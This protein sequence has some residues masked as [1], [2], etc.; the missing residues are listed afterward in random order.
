MGVLVSKTVAPA[1]LFSCF[2][3]SD[4]GFI[5]PGLEGIEAHYKQR[6]KYA[7]LFTHNKDIRISSHYGNGSLGDPPRRGES[8]CGNMV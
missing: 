8:H 5:L 4:L 1:F 3:D 2:L 6:K 7:Y